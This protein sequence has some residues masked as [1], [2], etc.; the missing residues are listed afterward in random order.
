VGSEFNRDFN[1]RCSA[2]A[3]RFVYLKG[4]QRVETADFWQLEAARQAQAAS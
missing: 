4:L 2:V 1:N 3:K